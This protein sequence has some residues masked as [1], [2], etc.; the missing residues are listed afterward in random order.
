MTLRPSLQ[1]LGPQSSHLCNGEKPGVSVKTAHTPKPVDK[2][3]WLPEAG[4]AQQ[5]WRGQTLTEQRLSGGQ[6]RPRCTGSGFPKVSRS[7]GHLVPSKGMEAAQ[8]LADMCWLIL[9]LPP[10]GAYGM[11][12]TAHRVG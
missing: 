1:V 7:M 10:T 3:Q 2:C 11:H 12:V 6:L 4:E 9:V 5:T 8:W